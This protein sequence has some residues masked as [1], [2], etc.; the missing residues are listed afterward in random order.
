MKE[1]CADSALVAYA[2]PAVLADAETVL[3]VALRGQHF[4]A[5]HSEEKKK[6]DGQRG[7]E[8][9]RR[10]ASSVPLF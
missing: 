10:Q 5:E 7:F 9:A 8:W 3:A 2:E 4:I 1:A 6:R